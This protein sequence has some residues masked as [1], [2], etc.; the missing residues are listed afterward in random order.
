MKKYYDLIL[1]DDYLPLTKREAQCLFYLL[2]GKTAKQTARRIHLATK[3]VEMYLD[4]LKQKTR[5]E[6]KL[7]LVC[8]YFLN[9]W[10]LKYDAEN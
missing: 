5:S 4:T 9:N 8:R 7:K 10:Q 3:T 6:T 1:H 2:H